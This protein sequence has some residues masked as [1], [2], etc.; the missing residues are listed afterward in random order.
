MTKMILIVDGDQNQKKQLEYSLHMAGY[1]VKLAVGRDEALR[2]L[3]AD[4]PGTANRPDIATPGRKWS[5][6]HGGF[7][8]LIGVSAAMKQTVLLA[9]RGAGSNIPILLEGESG[10]GKELFARAI[11]RESERRDKAFIVINCGAIPPNLVESLL[12]GHEKG[13]FTG[14]VERHVGKFV[15][16]DGGTLFLDEIGELPLGLQVKLLRVL[17]EGEVTPVGGGAPVTV[18]VR[19]ISATN[20]SLQ[21]MV[22]QGRFREDLFYRLNVFPIH[23]PALWQRKDDIDYL[24]RHFI[25]NISLSEGCPEKNISPAA[26]E[27]LKN[28]SWPG[29]IRQLENTL[30]RAIILSE[31]AEITTADFPQIHRDAAGRHRAVITDDMPSVVDNNG[32]I[33]RV[34]DVE[35]DMIRFALS[36]YNGRM[37]EVARRLGF[38]R[39]TL[40]RKVA[41]LGL[42][43]RIP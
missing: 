31:F 1:D 42:D 2:L 27:L 7:K 13:A 29:N 40:Y 22:A 10:V 11:Q 20:Q 5:S 28:Y 35:K 4:E 15:E 14:A 36:R 39:S 32:D 21:D 34:C 19:L 24:V 43:R 25:K 33:R 18:D 23:V 26:M 17:Q 6:G 9:Q 41:E 3:S 16:A 38:G 30:F 37:S 12:F 8:D